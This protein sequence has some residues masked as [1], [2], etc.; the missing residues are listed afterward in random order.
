LGANYGIGLFKQLQE[1]IEQV[2]KL[3]AEIREIKS[4]YRM[5]T[6]SLKT[7]IESLRKENTALK[8]ENQKLKAIVNKDSGNSSKPPSSDAFKKIFNSREK[9][10][11]RPGGQTGHPGSVPSLFEN[12]ACIIDHKRE[13]CG[14]GGTVAYGEGY[15]AKQTVELEIKAKVTEHRSYTGFCGRCNA[16]VKNDMPL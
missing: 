7:E 3:T 8:A 12:P 10:G 15:Q 16:E 1:T 11:R 13:R 14:C 5:E 2:E 4:A 9:T 6:E